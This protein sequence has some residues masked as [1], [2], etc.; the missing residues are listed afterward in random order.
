MSR[1]SI[2][3][4][5][6]SVLLLAGLVAL[7]AATTPAMPESDSAIPA[8]VSEQ[9][10][11]DGVHPAVQRILAS[12]GSAEVLTAEEMA[13]IPPTVA[14]VLLDRGVVLALGP[15]GDR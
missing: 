8:A 11:V 12:I 5:T 15:G 14:R 10:T 7:R 3:G 13:Q 4:I 2:E 6:G 9:V 1:F